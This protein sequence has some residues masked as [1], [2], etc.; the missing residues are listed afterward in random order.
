MTNMMKIMIKIIKKTH[1]RAGDRFIRT[2]Q[3]YTMREKIVFVVIRR[4]AE[5]MIQK[6]SRRDDHRH[7]SRNSIVEGKFLACL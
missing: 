1:L 7:V 3:I 2:V 4:E 6:R 5:E